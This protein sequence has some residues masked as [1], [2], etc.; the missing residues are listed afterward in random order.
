[1]SEPPKHEMPEAPCG[2]QCSKDAGG[3]ISVIPNRLHWAAINGEPQDTAEVHYFSVDD[4]LV[5]QPFFHD[6]GPLNLGMICRFCH[7]VHFKLADPTMQGKLVVHYCS[8][9]PANMANA[10]FLVC[11]YQVVVLGVLPA[12]A[13]Q[14]FSCRQLKFMPFRDALC[15]KC[16]FELTISDCLEALQF[17]IMKGWFNWTRFNADSYEYFSMVEHGDMNWIIPGKFLAYAGPSA[18]PV[19]ADGYP[20]LMPEDYV[21]VFVQ[22]GIGLTI[23]LNKPAY[24]KQRFKDAG[25]RHLDLYFQD[26]SC[27]SWNIISRFLHVTENEKGA[28]AVHCKAGLGRTGTLIGLY[29]MK[30]HF[31]PA[32]PFIA[33]N[34]I[35]RP[36]SILG[37]QQQF[38]VDMQHDM[39]QAGL[40]A[41]GLRQRELVPVCQRGPSKEK[42]PDATRIPSKSSAEAYE[43]VGQGERLVNAKRGSGTGGSGHSKEADTLK[44]DADVFVPRAQRHGETTGREADVRPHLS[45]GGEADHGPHV[46]AGTEFSAECLLSDGSESDTTASHV[47][48]PYD[49]ESGDSTLAAPA[50]NPR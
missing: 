17:S 6:F 48:G 44:A 36:G 25:M 23:R 41:Q 11:A 34:R 3:Q 33:W 45:G 7:L 43:D 38:L 20:A 28:V 49:S 5:Y 10:A 50:V 26:G 15:R 13:F 21:E 9:D 1:M 18:T 40:A 29:S 32:R 8:R 47:G 19:D 14:P 37:P 31:F 30:N 16:T 39:F 2:K 12:T 22:A 24:D 35:C 42:L 46:K 27:P 4:E